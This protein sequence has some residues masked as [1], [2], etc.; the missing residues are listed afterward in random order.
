LLHSLQY[1][2]GEIVQRVFGKI[3][4]PPFGKEWCMFVVHARMLS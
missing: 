4:V 1:R 3:L 2:I